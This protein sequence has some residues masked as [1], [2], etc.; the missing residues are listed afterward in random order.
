[1]AIKR[2]IAEADN[3]ITNAFET[4]LITRATK[5]NMGAADVLET[6]VI[7]GQTSSSIR[8]ENA[9]E[10]R[11]IIQFPVSGTNAAIET[12]HRDRSNN[13]IPPQGKVSFYLRMFNARHAETTPEDFDLD[14]KILSKTWNEGR[15][16]D[17]DTYSDTGF[18]SWLSSSSGSAWSSPGGDFHSA[19]DTNNFSASVNFK[20]G[21]EDIEVDVT[22][23]VENWVDGTKANYGF[24]LKHIASSLSGNNGTLYTKKF[25]ARTTEFFFRRPVIEARWDDSRKDHRGS[26]FISSSLLDQTDNINRLYLY[27]RFRGQLK[28]IIYGAITD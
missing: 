28:N 25:F 6:F 23:A 18:S 3:T 26:F 24:L 8:A 21:F 19:V 2:Y 15:G 17:M 20:H 1:M 12:I 13:V 16:L 10:A 14:V 22:T 4:N 5:A 27:N 11:I 9:E 7:H